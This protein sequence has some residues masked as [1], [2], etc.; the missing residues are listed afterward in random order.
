MEYIRS[1]QRSLFSDK[2]RAELARTEHGGTVRRHRRKLE[3]PVSTRRPMHIVLSSRRARGAWDL[4]EHDRAVRKALRDMARQFS[5][6]VYEFAN[7]G[8]HLHMLVRARRRDAFQNFLRSF[9]GIV[10]RKVT[11]ARR[12]RPSGRFFAGLAWSRVVSWGRDCL[13]VRHYIFRNEIEASAGSG[14]RR[15]MEIGTPSARRRQTPTAG[16]SP[17]RD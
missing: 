4:R 14:V 11:G 16:R 7:V 2:L 9:A 17:P 8:A 6:R 3:R 5:V 15:A 13:G 10:A 1:V 12:G